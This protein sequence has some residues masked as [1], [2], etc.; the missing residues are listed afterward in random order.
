MWNCDLTVNKGR[1]TIDIMAKIKKEVRYV[2]SKMQ[3]VIT[4]EKTCTAESIISEKQ[5]KAVF[6]TEPLE[7]ARV[8]LKTYTGEI[9]PVLQQFQAKVIYDGQSVTL[10]VIKG[11]GP[12]CVAGIGC[13]NSH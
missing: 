4:A 10:N 11:K 2:I 6:S 7:I 3:S 12:S 9:M 8:K 5:F 13:K 1:S